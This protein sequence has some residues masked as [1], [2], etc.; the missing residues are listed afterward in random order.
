MWHVKECVLADLEAN[1]NQ[2]HREGIQE[3]RITYDVTTPPDVVIV[4]FR[5][6]WEEPDVREQD[7]ADDDE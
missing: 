2:L 7:L 4:Y 5:D 3:G 1:L 6:D